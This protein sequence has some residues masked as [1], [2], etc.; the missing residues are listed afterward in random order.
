LRY[1]SLGMSGPVV[2]GWIM[3]LDCVDALECMKEVGIVVRMTVMCSHLVA[4]ALR[5]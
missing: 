2:V 5:I 4:R 3:S 1:G